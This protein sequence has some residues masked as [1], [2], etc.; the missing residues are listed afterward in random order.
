MKIPACVYRDSYPQSRSSGFEDQI[1]DETIACLTLIQH[2]IIREGQDKHSKLLPLSEA[3]GWTGGT[4]QQNCSMG[5]WVNG[6]VYLLGNKGVHCCKSLK[7]IQLL[8]S[9]NALCHQEGKN[10]ECQ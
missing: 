1:I 3:M 4:R 2:T 6:T 7:T 8:K 10:K 5:S 9:Q